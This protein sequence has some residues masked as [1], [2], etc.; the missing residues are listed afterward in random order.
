MSKRILVVPDVHGESFWRKPVLKYIDQVDR[1]I[2]LGDYLDPYKDKF[3]EYDA[4]AVFNNMMEIVNLKLE[5][6]EKVILLKGNHDFHYSSTRAF[7]LAS[8]SRCDIKNWH[9]YNKLFIDYEELFKLAYIEDVKGIT[10]LFSHAGLTTYWINK[11]NA[12]IWKL[13][14]G[15]I[16]VADKDI[17][18]K[19]NMLEYDFEGQNMLAIIGKSR[20]IKGEK[21]GSILW[22][23]IYEH[24]IPDAPKVYGLNQV[25][26]VFG[27]TRLEEDIAAF[28]NLALIDSQ[29]CFIIDENIKENI[30]TIKD[31]E[32]KIMDKNSLTNV[33]F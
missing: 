30:I 27:H 15:E 16:S 11:V 6:K 8:A 31:Y 32:F 4:E 22:A 13:N 21:S 7:L 2:F 12:K 9:R 24:S 25:Y 3:E 1:I 28:D 14:D 33:T 20:S 19:I 18:D 29:Q 23:D 26:Q 10:Y 17:I 5:N